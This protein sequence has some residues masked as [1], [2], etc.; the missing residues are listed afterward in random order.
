MIRTHRWIGV[1]SVAYV[2]LASVLAVRWYRYQLNPDAISYISIAR[3]YAHGHL[4]AALNGFWGPL[5][6]WLIVPFIWAGIN[7]II[8]AKLIIIFAGLGLLFV[9][10]CFLISKRASR[11]VA[12]AA[13]GLTLAMVVDMALS[14]PITPDLLLTLAIVWFAVRL[15]SFVGKPQRTAGIWL[16]L[17]GALMYFS[18]GFGFYLFL[19]TVSLVAMWQWLAQKLTLRA[20]FQNWLPVVITF[21]VIVLPFVTA[22]SWK[23]QKPTIS[24]AGAFDHVLFGPAAKGASGPWLVEGPLSPH[25]STAIWAGEDPSYLQQLLPGNGWSPFDSKHSLKYFVVST[26]GNNLR[27]TIDLLI[28]FGPAVAAGVLILLV[29]WLGKS[30]RQEYALFALVGLLMSGG[31]A[32]VLTEGRYLAG[33]AVLAI[34]GLGLAATS[35]QKVKVI[36]H[37]QTISAG[38]IIVIVAAIPVW[39]RTTQNSYT[40]RPPYLAAMSLQG[41]IPANSRAMTDA[42]TGY[43]DC[44]YLGLQC[45]GTLAT[46]ITKPDSYYRKLQRA[47]VQ[48]YIDHHS[49]SH[50]TVVNNFL[51]SHFEKLTDRMN[52]S[53]LITVYRLR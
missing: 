21:G 16:G 37:W 31:Y 29:G 6:S 13:A 9:V 5:L 14:G 4:P 46:V 42:Y 19:G 47:H 10:Y 45:L 18:K 48:Y 35:L 17:S 33:F 1:L 53:Q 43:Y 32:L 28:G 39:Q 24:N 52:G 25:S 41:I 23:Y 40:D 20:V 2:I 30:N 26:V 36:N 15:N 27:K 49:I 44:Y 11:S 12:L 7:P 22:I 3:E 51:D 34:L 38:L 8:A 50:N